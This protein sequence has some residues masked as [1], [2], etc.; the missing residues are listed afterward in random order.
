MT[1]RTIP[2]TVVKKYVNVDVGHV[3]DIAAWYDDHG[4]RGGRHIHRQGDIYTNT[5]IDPRIAR[6]RK[7][8][9]ECKDS[10]NEQENQS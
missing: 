8:G 10:S 3:V 9:C 6:P 1:M 2:V 5:D 4:W 7:H